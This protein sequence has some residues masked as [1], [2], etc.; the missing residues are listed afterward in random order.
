MSSHEDAHLRI[1]KVVAAEPE[2]SQRQLAVR[3]GVSLGKTNFLIRSL[4][5][6]GLLKA[7]NFRRA[8]NKLQYAY[9]LTPKGIGAKVRLTRAYLARKE[10]E[11]EGL[12]AEIE[13]LRQE[14]KTTHEAR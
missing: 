12:R 6:K 1:L 10:A 14:M 8:K 13:L 3:L 9:L 11:Y 5:E 7:R 4:L 2:I